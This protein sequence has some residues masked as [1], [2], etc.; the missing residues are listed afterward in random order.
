MPFCVLVHS[1]AGEQ[2]GI[3]IADST[4]LAVC[5]NLRISRN[6][7]FEGLAKRGKTTTGWFFGFKLHGVI[8]HKGEIMA[9]K[10]TPGN[11]DDRA[12]LDAMTREL[13]GKVLADKGYISRKLFSKLWQRGLHLIT[14]IRR[15]MKNYLMPVLDKLL[16]R[17]RFI[18]ETLF[19]RLKSQMGLEHTRHRSKTN[20]FVHMLSCVTA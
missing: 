2:T 1:L 18:I 11:T 13:K 10:I 14:G 8:N 7:V 16:L 17:K 3:Y 19:D 9:V 6:R 5:H 15:N 4:R 12:V 20:A